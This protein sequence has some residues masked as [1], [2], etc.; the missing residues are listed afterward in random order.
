MTRASFQ[1]SLS[2]LARGLVGTAS[3]QS[4]T[5]FGL[6]DVAVEHVTKVG[7]SGRGLY[8]MPS[9]TGRL[10]SRWGVRGSEGLGGGLRAVFTLEHCFTPDMARSARAGVPSAAGP[11]WARRPPGAR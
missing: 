6:I 9:L 10:P 7:A 1:L 8:R 5:L 4:V 11:G 3:A 2:G